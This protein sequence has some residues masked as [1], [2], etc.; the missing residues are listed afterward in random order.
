MPPRMPSIDESKYFKAVV[1]FRSGTPSMAFW[2]SNLS[3]TSESVIL[4]SE[5]DGKVQPGTTIE[6]S[7]IALLTLDFDAAFDDEA[8]A[9]QPPA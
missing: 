7:R 3:V 1:E 8:Q 5:I 2:G 9:D 6:R 4:E